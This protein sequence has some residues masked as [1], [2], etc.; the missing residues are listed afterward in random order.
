MADTGLN[1][2]DGTDGTGRK[3]AGR[4]KAGFT[5]FFGSSG[6]RTLM[7]ILAIALFVFMQL[8]VAKWLSPGSSTRALEG[9]ELVYWGFTVLLVLF[10]VGVERRPLS[11]V[12]LRRLR[13]SDVAIGVAA[14]L[15]LVAIFALFYLVVVPMTGLADDAKQMQGIA[16]LPVWLRG[17]IVVRAAVFE[18]LCYRGFAIERLTEATGRRYVA[19]ALSLVAFVYAHL[20]Y[21]GWSHL[22]VV[23]IGGCVLTGLYL[24]HRNLAQTMIAHFVTDAVAFLAAT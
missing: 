2:P 6:D 17:A 4:G 21:W 18:E 7:S 19:A 12:G 1:I 16:G 11:S 15:A 10:V 13:W 9:G 8:P 22:I 24:W 14:G 5:A 3:V 20:D 23:A